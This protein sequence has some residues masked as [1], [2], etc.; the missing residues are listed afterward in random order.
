MSQP[1]TRYDYVSEERER[2]GSPRPR[3]VIRPPFMATSL[4]R[5]ESEQRH[6]T[7]TQLFLAISEV[8]PRGRS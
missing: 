1:N 2:G 6:P 8:E 7:I 3:T 5:T 4:A